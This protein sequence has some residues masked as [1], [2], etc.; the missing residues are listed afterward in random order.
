[1]APP[2]ARERGA[3][4]ERR[5]NIQ[6][7]ALT[8]GSARRSRRSRP[9]SPRRRVRCGRAPMSRRRDRRRHATAPPRH[10]RASR[11]SRDAAGG[12]IGGAKESVAVAELARLERIDEI[13]RHA[14]A[15][16]GEKIAIVR[17]RRPLLFPSLRR[18][19]KNRAIGSGTAL[20]ES[21][22]KGPAKGPLCRLCDRIATGVREMRL[23]EAYANA[24]AE[25]SRRRSPAANSSSIPSAAR[26][27]PTIPSRAVRF[28]PNMSSRVRLSWATRR[29]SSK[30]H[31]RQHV[32]TPGWAR[33][34]AVDGS[35]IADFS[36][37]PGATDTQ[38]R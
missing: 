7:R 9:P 1:M 6:T 18:A 11:R 14:H 8:P 13:E 38:D 28:F 5:G 35:V 36:A 37:G 10:R 32:G 20:A 15:A 24:S 30:I 12:V 34:F 27:A 4:R 2:R 22:A 19:D 29:P 16:V 17:H 3:A 33:A 21:A 23:A 31:R 26:R 25:A